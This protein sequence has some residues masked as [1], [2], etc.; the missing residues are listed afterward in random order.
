MSYWGIALL[1]FPAERVFYYVKSGHVS[2]IAIFD[3]PEKSARVFL[4]VI[5][6][7]GRPAK[8]F[9]A[10][11]RARRDLM[12]VTGSYRRGKRNSATA[13]ISLKRLAHSSTT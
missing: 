9:L 12:N 10:R 5:R 6:F 11:T 4:P 1:V 3:G 2:E 8:Q 7:L 13:E